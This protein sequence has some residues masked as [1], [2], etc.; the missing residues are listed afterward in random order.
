MLRGLWGS[1]QK[2]V[3]WEGSPEEVTCQL[4]LEGQV[5]IQQVSKVERIFEDLELKDKPEVSIGHRS[6]LYG[7]NP[8]ILGLYRT[9]I[10]KLGLLTLILH[11]PL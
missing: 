5:G 11:A 4:S 3:F 7:Q 6:K 10:S 9:N 2:R 8:Q 1:T